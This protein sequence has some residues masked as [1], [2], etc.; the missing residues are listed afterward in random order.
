MAATCQSKAN[1]SQVSITG[2]VQNYCDPFRQEKEAGKCHLLCRWQW[3]LWWLWWDME[4][5][6][7]KGPNFTEEVEIQKTRIARAMLSDAIVRQCVKIWN[8]LTNHALQ[9]ILMIYSASI[10]QH[11]RVQYQRI[12]TIL[13]SLE[14]EDHHKDTQAHIYVKHKIWCKIKVT[15]RYSRRGKYEERIWINFIFMATVFS[16]CCIT[17]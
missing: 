15:L 12:T 17:R 9:A 5:W 1:V 8:I 10:S 7:V 3:W 11:A 2:V 4:V 16:C 14:H 6:E 13:S